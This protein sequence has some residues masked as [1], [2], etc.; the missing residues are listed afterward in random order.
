MVTEL[1]KFNKFV[2][3]LHLYILFKDIYLNMC[4]VSGFILHFVD[5]CGDVA[6]PSFVGTIAQ[7]KAKCVDS[8]VANFVGKNFIVEKLSCSDVMMKY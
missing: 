8:A 3:N 7:I 4:T 1:I 5:Q 2:F 6:K